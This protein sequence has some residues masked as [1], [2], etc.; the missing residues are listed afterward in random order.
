MI[1]AQ[2]MLCSGVANAQLEDVRQ[3]LSQGANP[4]Q[5][6]EEGVC[7]L[8]IWMRQTAAFSYSHDASIL[9]LSEM[10]SVLPRTLQEEALLFSILTEQA[11]QL[12]FSLGV[13]DFLNEKKLPSHH[14]LSPQSL[15]HA[16]LTFA[17]LRDALDK[18]L[19]E[20]PVFRVEDIVEAFARGFAQ[21]QHSIH[22]KGL[23][24]A[25]VK[26]DPTE[27]PSDRHLV[28]HLLSLLPPRPFTL[29]P[30][31]ALCLAELEQEKVMELP[32]SGQFLSRATGLVSEQNHPLTKLQWSDRH[33]LDPYVPL[34]NPPSLTIRTHL[35][36]LSDAL[37]AKNW[38]RAE[39]LCRKGAHLSDLPFNKAADV[40]LRLSSKSDM[41]S[42]M[43]LGFDPFK[44]MFSM[45][46]Q[47]G[48]LPIDLAQNQD[49][50]DVLYTSMKSKNPSWVH[51]AKSESSRQYRDQMNSPRAHPLS[52]VEPSQDQPPPMAHKGL[53]LRQALMR[54]RQTWASDSSSFAPEATNKPHKRR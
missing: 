29:T 45:L 31:G 4:Y 23:G 7:P 25:E 20:A 12:S 14:S 21:A 6:N 3:A 9:C 10:L 50:F 13:L 1:S 51:H 2:D 5:K 32:L 19:D 11:K 33:P 53:S 24:E 38:V 36:R 39:K 18:T 42:M 47:D 30:F 8:E 54:M 28:N 52:I 48:M 34:S 40:F 37:D 22:P 44:P 27:V 35:K 26:Y 43:A 49:Q 46:G 17:L 15:P 16:Q 41:T